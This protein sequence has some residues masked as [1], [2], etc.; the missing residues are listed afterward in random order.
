MFIH[1]GLYSVAGGEW[2]DQPVKEGYSE[3]IQAHARIPMADY[4]KLAK[5]FR[6]PKWDP[7][8]VARLAK[9]AGMKYVV[10]TS[11]HH[12][13]FSMFGTKA[14]DYNVV[15]ATPYRRDVIQG[16]A[17]ACARQGLK[18]G[19]YY[20][21]IDWHFPGGT[22]IDMPR[23]DNAI[24]PAHEKFNVAQLRELMSNYGPLTEIW[25]DMGKPTPQQSKRF[26]DTVH[27][28]QPDCMVSGR[29]FNH[30]GDFTVMGDNRIPDYVIDEPWQ[31]PASIYHE[32]WGYRSWQKRE[33]QAGK[34][35]EHIVKL[36]EVVSRGGN[37]LLNIGPRGDG[38]VVEF[39]A[40]ILQGIGEWL[41]VNGEA[42]YATQP[43]PFRN[44]DFGHATVTPGRLYLLVRNWPRDGKLSLPG[45]QTK[46]RR[47][48]Y[49]ADPQ[50]EP[51]PL[52][53]G[54]VDVSR[55]RETA[56]VTVVVAEYD[57]ALTVSQPVIGGAPGDSLTLM[58]QHADH[59]YNYNGQG[60]Y[61]PP[62]VYKLQWNFILPPGQ[63]RVS[64]SLS[65]VAVEVDG[66][67]VAE[68]LQL[69]EYTSHV[70]TLTPRKPFVKGDRLP[71]G[72]ASVTLRKE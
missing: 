29:V 68:R 39:E 52:A 31:T 26:A 43:Q 16:L 44:L 59:F 8:A 72:A 54:V 64:A 2:N 11:K 65:G 49:L 51:L 15:K 5:Q 36:V 60:Y 46:L 45:L 6:A 55:K 62:S 28:L 63:Y 67:P 7:D 33:D 58:E 20:S 42:I 13:G 30:Q 18:F 24:P 3:Q 32:T 40:S 69:T 12:D 61:E 66:R 27:S 70:L 47:A 10:I 48:Y 22:G 1:W 41:K 14:S 71:P 35:N 57:G 19:V 56:P 21:T 9:A 34:T 50:Q 4:G 23:N 53:A 25:F 37:Y 17:Q 38:S